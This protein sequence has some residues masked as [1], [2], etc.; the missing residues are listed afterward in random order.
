MGSAAIYTGGNSTEEARIYRHKGEVLFIGAYWE[1]SISFANYH[2]PERHMGAAGFATNLPL[3]LE[4]TDRPAPGILPFHSITSWPQH[5]QGLTAQSQ[6]CSAA[7]Q[8][9]SARSRMGAEMHGLYLS[10]GSNDRI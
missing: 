6:C 9:P 2:D 4:V 8:L 5:P 3:A 10:R 1:M 7:A